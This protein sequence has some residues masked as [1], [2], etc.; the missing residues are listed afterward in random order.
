M[1]AEIETKSPILAFI[2]KVVPLSVI[3][4]PVLAVLPTAVNTAPTGLVPSIVLTVSEHATTT[5]VML[6]FV[7]VTLGLTTRQSLPDG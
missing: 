2:V 1:A 3:A 6:L 4:L 7:T 5:D